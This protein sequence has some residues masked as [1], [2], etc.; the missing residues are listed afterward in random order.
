MS[1]VAPF[2][3]FLLTGSIY[4]YTRAPGLSWQFGGTDG[5]ELANAVVLAGIAHP[6][7]YPLYIILGKIFTTLLFFIPPASA[8]TLLSA[9]TMSLGMMFLYNTVANL[10]PDASPIMLMSVIFTF[11]FWPLAWSQA[12]IVE[13]YSLTFMLW[14]LI[15]WM[16][17]SAYPLYSLAFLIGLSLGN[18]L[19]L[20]VGL[21][22]LIVWFVL[23]HPPLRSRQGF[24][25]LML[26][27]LGISTYLWLPLHAGEAP[28]SNW[29]NPDNFDRFV[30]HIMGKIYRTY[31]FKG[32]YSANFTNWAKDIL[33]GFAPL[34][35]TLPLGIWHFWEKN[36]P[37][38]FGSLI[39][40]I[41]VGLYRMGY[42]AEGVDAYWLLPTSLLVIFISAGVMRWFD[43]IDQR[44][45]IIILILPLIQLIIHFDDMNLRHDH[46]PKIFVEQTLLPLPENA[47]LLLDDEREIFTLWYALYAENQRSDVWVIDVRMLQWD[48]YIEN[49]KAQYP[50]LNL[51]NRYLT[52]PELLTAIPTQ[53]PIYARF[54]IDPR[55]TNRQ[56]FFLAN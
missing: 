14:S 17:S 18:H 42:A 16:L 22:G 53:R 32:D 5:G 7:G 4:F 20:L 37:F 24:I 54:E 50:D 35:L 56:I 21:P 8:L 23:T 6:S 52:L 45:V 10:L 44:L 48:W 40:G 34:L 33:E 30:T 15:L 26:F 46:E 2:L 41:S 38:L 36:R 1:R 9:L 29:G 3:V 13:V 19:I 49:L 27:L 25:M 43:L 39:S 55:L 47:V 28:E 51:P 11:A 31:Q 12:L